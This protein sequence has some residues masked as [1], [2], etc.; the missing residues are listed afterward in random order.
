MLAHS[1]SGKVGGKFE[2]PG[3]SDLLRCQGG[4]AVFDASQ[5]PLAAPCRKHT[6]F[7]RDDFE[8]GYELHSGQAETVE[9]LPFHAM[10]GYP[11]DPQTQARDE[12]YWH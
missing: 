4:D 2:A 10:K 3:L 11:Y 1:D 8:K 12:A 9:G 5:L 7:Y 6:F